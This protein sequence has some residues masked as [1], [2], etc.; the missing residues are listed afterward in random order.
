MFL[1]ED[2]WL[3]IVYDL[4]YGMASPYSKTSHLGL[5]FSLSQCVY[6]KRDCRKTLK[7]QFLDL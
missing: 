3:P 1:V 7:S 2:Q 4:G 5:T 6:F